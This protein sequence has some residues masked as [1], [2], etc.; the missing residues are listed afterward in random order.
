MKIALAS[1]HAGFEYKEAI[2]AWLS[3]HQ[4]QVEDFGTSSSAPVDY[5]DFIRLAAEAVARGECERA[6]VLGGSGNGEAIAAN[7]VRGIRCALCWSEETARLARQHNDA[8]ALSIGQRMISRE[9]ALR[10]V[11]IWLTTAFEGGRHEARI[12]KIE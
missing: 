7:K 10:I 12:R 5:P 1:D 9:L 2:K 3:A 6:I 8:N 11:E 4:H